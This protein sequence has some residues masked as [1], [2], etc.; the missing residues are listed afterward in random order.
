MY[1]L[2]A[3]L[4][5]VISF[6]SNPYTSQ[7]LFKAFLMRPFGGMVIGYMGDKYGR[8]YAL[9]LKSIPNGNTDICNGMFTNVFTSGG[10]VNNLIGYLQTITRN[11]CWWSATSVVDLYC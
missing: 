7:S 1:I 4:I 5:Y 11:V 3:T 10:V 8:K 9:V 2:C 6:H